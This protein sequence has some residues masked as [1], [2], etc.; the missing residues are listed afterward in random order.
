MKKYKVELHA[1]DGTR[2]SKENEIVNEN[3]LI[4]HFRRCLALCV[5]GE[6]IVVEQVK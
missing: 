4:E 6:T 2:L 3:K 5:P 1:K